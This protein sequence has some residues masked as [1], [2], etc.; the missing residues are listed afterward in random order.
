MDVRHPFIPH[1]HRHQW[2]F[3]GTGD[4][5]PSLMAHVTHGSPES[6]MRDFPLDPLWRQ[7]LGTAWGF[8]EKWSHQDDNGRNRR[9]LSA[10][11]VSHFVRHTGLKVT[12]LCGRDCSQVVG[13]GTRARLRVSAWRRTPCNPHVAFQHSIANVCVVIVWCVSRVEARTVL[14]H[15]A[16]QRPRHLFLEPHRTALCEVQVSALGQASTDSGAAG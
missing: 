11:G 8:G 1:Y 6:K 14:P 9:R 15:S 2:A 13:A 4:G 10:F 3:A 7:I 16:E 12:A 5:G